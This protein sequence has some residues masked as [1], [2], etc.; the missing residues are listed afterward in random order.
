ME[1]RRWE[2]APPPP[3]SLSQLVRHATSF[4]LL[5]DAEETGPVELNR[6][7]AG[8]VEDSKAETRTRDHT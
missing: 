4:H 3:L 5:S 1:V 7:W 8:D 6:N 2:T